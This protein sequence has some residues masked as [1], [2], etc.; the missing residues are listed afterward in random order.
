MSRVFWYFLLQDAALNVGDMTAV[1]PS[2][3]E[4]RELHAAALFPGSHYPLFCPAGIK[5]MR[6]FLFFLSN[7]HQSVEVEL[8]L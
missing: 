2:H 8:P 4:K 6:D 3:N 7:F 5:E 1:D